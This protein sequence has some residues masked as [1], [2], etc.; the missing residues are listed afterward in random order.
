MVRASEIDSVPTAVDDVVCTSVGAPVLLSL[1]ANDSGP[2]GN[3]PVTVVGIPAH[4]TLTPDVVTGTAIFTP[5]AGYSGLDAFTYR[6]TSSGGGQS[7]LATVTLKI[8]I[9]C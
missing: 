2:L 8:G 1:L 5:A 7:A 9:P 3:S 6:L 4:G